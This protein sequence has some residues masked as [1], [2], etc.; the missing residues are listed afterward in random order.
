[1][2]IARKDIC[3]LTNLSILTPAGDREEVDMIAS[4]KLS[5]WQQ[6]DWAVHNSNHS[7]ILV[8]PYNELFRYLSVL[9]HFRGLGSEL[10]WVLTKVNTRTHTC[11]VLETETS[12][13]APPYGP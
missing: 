8:A 9:T 11:L 4:N 2:N 5:P 6:L 7:G 13:P 3:L 1:M 10:R 12:P